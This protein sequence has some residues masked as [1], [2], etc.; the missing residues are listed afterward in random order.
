MPIALYLAHTSAIKTALHGHHAAHL[1]NPVKQFPP[2][3]FPC[4]LEVTDQTTARDLKV[5]ETGREINIHAC[6]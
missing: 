2:L 1:V 6:Q 4:T 3:P 5:G